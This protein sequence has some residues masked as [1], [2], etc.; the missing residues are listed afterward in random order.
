MKVT[1]IQ[2]NITWADSRSNVEH[3]NQLIDENPGADLY[4]LPEMFSTGFTTAPE[5]I[6]ETEDY[7]LI[8]M[9][10]K[11]QQTNAALC[12]SVAVG[13]DGHYFNRC[14]FVKPGHK[15]VYYDKRHLF[16]YGKEHLKYQHGNVRVVTE[17]KGVRIL[18]QTCYDLRFPVFSR[19]KKDYDMVLYVASWPERRQDVWTTLIRARAIENQCYVAGVN[20]VGNDPQCH[21]LGGS[22]IIN[23]YGKYMAK[24]VDDAESTCVADIDMDSLNSFRCKFPVLDDADRF[25][26]V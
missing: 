16:T 15:V 7:S 5:G 4:V 14:Y 12:G 13:I 20:R 2:A 6:A 17:W 25:N 21:Y 1:L 11:S 18:L 22:A 9:T 10:E 19:N 3:F 24:C 8:W 26:I 23:P